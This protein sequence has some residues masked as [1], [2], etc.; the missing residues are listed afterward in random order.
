VFYGPVERD[1]A[2]FCFSSRRITTTAALFGVSNPIVVV[3]HDGFDGSP[4]DLLNHVFWIWSIAYQITKAEDLIDTLFVYVFQNGVQSFQV[5]VH[6]TE[7]HQTHR[8]TSEFSSLTEAKIVT[9]VFSSLLQE[10]QQERNTTREDQ[11]R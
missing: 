3:S 1:V 10:F 2:N 5:R 6:I 11:S 8:F 4:F 9:F 7:E